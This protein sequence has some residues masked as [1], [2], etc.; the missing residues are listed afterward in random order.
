[1][2]KASQRRAAGFGDGFVD[3]WGAEALARRIAVAR[4]SA[5]DTQALATGMQ[6]RHR[7]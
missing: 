2:K 1:M 6:S 5:R 4:R 7:V 3:G